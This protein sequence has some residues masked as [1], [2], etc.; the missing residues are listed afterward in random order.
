MHPG[1]ASGRLLKDLL[2]DFITKSGLTKCYQ[3]NGELTR[4]TFSIDHKLPWLHSNNPIEMFFDINNIA[5][6]HLKCNSGAARRRLSTAKCGTKA[7]YQK[8]CRCMDCRR[9][10]AS[11]AKASYTT[12][13][14]REKYE[15]EKVKV[16]ERR[17]N[18]KVA[19]L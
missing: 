7:R 8:G 11:L 15:R 12:E 18:G 17:Q 14:R 5:Y 16:L 2:F 4:E 10:I 3:C 6:S 13:K 1:T 9:K 19:T